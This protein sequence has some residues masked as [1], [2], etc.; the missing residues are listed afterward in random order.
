MVARTILAI[1]GPIMLVAGITIFV[2]MGDNLVLPL[3]GIVLIVIGIILLSIATRWDIR[4]L[5]KSK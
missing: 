1:L 4:F 2:I 3:L 5:R